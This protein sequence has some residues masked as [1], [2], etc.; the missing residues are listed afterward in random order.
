MDTPK[1]SRGE[2]LHRLHPISALQQPSSRARPGGRLRLETRD[3]VAMPQPHA[4]PW[5]YAGMIS[6][7]LCVG[8]GIRQQGPSLP[9]HPVHRLGRRQF[10]Q[11]RR[12]PACQAGRYRFALANRSSGS[13]PRRSANAAALSR[14]HRPIA[15]VFRRRRKPNAARALPNSASEPGSGT[16]RLPKR[17]SASPLMPAVK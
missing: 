6:P 17:P 10:A 2:M 13:R 14:N 11:R 15:A 8:D 1:C 7:R 9:V 12:R 3:L 4:S 16:W 5:A